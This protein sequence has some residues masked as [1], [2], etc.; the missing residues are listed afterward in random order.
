MGYG[1]RGGKTVVRYGLSCGY[2]TNRPTQVDKHVW[3]HLN[4]NPDDE[5]F[6]VFDEHYKGEKLHRCSE[7]LK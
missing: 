2:W 3:A 1:D 5:I 4:V 6:D 7:G